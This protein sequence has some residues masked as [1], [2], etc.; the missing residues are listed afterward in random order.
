MDERHAENL[1]PTLS[2]KRGH[3]VFCDVRGTHLLTQRTDQQALVL[4]VSSLDEPGGLRPCVAIG[5]AAT[6]D[7][8]HVPDGISVFDG[9]R[10]RA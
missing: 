3:T 4:K 10:P 5:H 2:R 7:F 6:P 9:L 1:C 8:H